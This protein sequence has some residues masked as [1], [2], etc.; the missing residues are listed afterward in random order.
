MS[1][2]YRNGDMPGMQFNRGMDVTADQLTAMEQ[3]LSIEI[4][5]R[6]KNFI[7]KPGFI[8]G[9]RIGEISG[10]NITVTAGEAFDQ[11]GRRLTQS[12]NIS[13]KVNTPTS[14]SS[15]SFLILRANP[16]DGGYRVHPYDGSRK[17]TE[18]IIGLEIA[19]ESSVGVTALGNYASNGD[20]L[21]LA[22]ITLSGN[23]YDWTY[24]NRS[25]NLEMQDGV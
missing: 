14:V 7:K 10:Q 5:E 4:Q 11:E 24:T 19:I 25:P 23:T 1:I 16:Q 8:R 20:G 21:V 3:Y 18:T 13:Y 15:S 12:R 17:P 9:F 6:T 22:D 2:T